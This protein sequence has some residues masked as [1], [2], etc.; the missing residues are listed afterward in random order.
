MAAVDSIDSNATG[1]RI[2]EEVSF[3][4][5]PGSPV[6]NPLEP[7][8]YPEFGG[9][10]TTIARN[11]INPSRQRKK[12]VVTDLDA[13]GGFNTDLTQTNLQ[14]PL[15]G[16]FFAS[17]RPKGEES[18]TA[19]DVDLANPDEY[20]VASTT[21]FQ[22]DDLI[23]G[24]N[25]AQLANN[26][27]N[28]VTGLVADTSVEVADGLLVAEPA[29]PADARIVVV[30]HQFQTGEVDIDAT[31]ALP[32]LVRAS[33]VKDF[34]TFGIIPGEPIFVGGDL[35]AEEWVGAEN[36]G[37]KRVRQVGVDFIEFDKSDAAMTDET[38]TGLTI[39]LFFGRVLKNENGTEANFPIV[40]RSYQ[41]ERT[42][43]A[44][45]DAQPTEI[46]AEYIEGATP[47]EA[48]FN[49]QGQDKLTVDLSYIGAD[50]TVIDGPTALKTGSRPALTES[51]A[52][53]TSSDFSRIKLAQ[54]VPGDEA[55]LPL[56]AFSTELT[57]T[58]N[59]NLSPN[60]AIGRLG[61]FQISAG[62]FQVGGN[63]TAYFSDVAAVAAVQNNADITLDFFL[64]KSNSGIAMDV[65]LITLGDGR[66][67][68]AQDEPITLPLSMDAATGASVDPLLDHTLLMVFFDYLPTAAE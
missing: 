45:D 12:G 38:G 1:L 11:P 68:V 8:S 27:L 59:N 42:L 18:V 43:G 22:L 62:T 9:Q 4:V 50:R 64:A 48:S 39:R 47:G 36:N 67:N 6:W 25:F 31:G 58:I 56:F 26:A 66:P 57:L 7:N 13:T 37:L 15:Q 49:L 19:V 28:V 20:E 16:H 41:L 55:P 52:F 63:I 34:T 14:D 32:R 17:L 33:G 54:V 53:N 21:G 24:Q 3:G 44:P 23:Q 65:P 35:T 2:A 51:D 10:V 60:K 29:P 61:A 40:K 30:G 5:L 46:Q